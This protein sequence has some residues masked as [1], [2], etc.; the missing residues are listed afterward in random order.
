[1]DK[2]AKTFFRGKQFWPVM[3]DE[4]V[5]NFKLDLR[6]AP[7]WV[8]AL[9]VIGGVVLG[10]ASQVQASVANSEKMQDLALL[11]FLLTLLTWGLNQWQ[12]N[13]SRWGIIITIIII[14]YW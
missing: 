8:I 5:S 2:L 12:P 4:P 7:V 10:L 14:V 9:M 1:M 3:K 11:V 13:L 6:I